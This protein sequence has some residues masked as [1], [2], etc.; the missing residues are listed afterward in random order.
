MKLSKQDLADIFDDAADFDGSNELAFDA[1]K[2]LEAG[3][4]EIEGYERTEWTKF[5]PNDP[6]TFPPKNAV[7]LVMIC[8]KLSDGALKKMAVEIFNEYHMPNWNGGTFTHWRPLPPPPGKEE[9]R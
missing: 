1:R 4:L 5:D 2:A 7:V 9:A 8:K 3:T 6:K